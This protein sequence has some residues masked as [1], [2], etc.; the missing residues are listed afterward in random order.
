MIEALPNNRPDCEEILKNQY[1]W[2]ISDEESKN[3]NFA[4]KVSF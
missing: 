4:E 2:A 3:Q 1:L